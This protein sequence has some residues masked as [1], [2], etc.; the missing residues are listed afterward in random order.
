MCDAC[1][2]FKLLSDGDGTYCT[3]QQEDNATYNGL[4][5]GATAGRFDIKRILSLRTGINFDRQPPGLTAYESINST[6][7][8]PPGGVAPAGKIAFN[9]IAIA[10][11]PV[12][13]NIVENWSEWKHGV[14]Q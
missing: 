14:P 11:L 1:R 5:R 9:N 3:T 4:K 13:Q 8:S 12:V 6:V 2:W 7:L 10:G